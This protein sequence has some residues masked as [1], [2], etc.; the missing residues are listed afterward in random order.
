MKVLT[1]IKSPSADHEWLKCSMPSFPISGVFDG[2]KGLFPDSSGRS[3]RATSPT[4]SDRFNPLRHS[5]CCLIP[6]IRCSTFT[7]DL[8]FS[9]QPLIAAD[10]SFRIGFPSAQCDPARSPSPPLPRDRCHALP[11]SVL[12]SKPAQA[13]HG[14]VLLP[15]PASRSPRCVSRPLHGT[16]ESVRFPGFQSLGLNEADG[17]QCAE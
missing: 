14:P 8:C 7:T 11:V 13:A 15:P 5:P 3:S 4:S 6:T 2:L 17:A 12:L 10:S 16:R 1:F 9:I